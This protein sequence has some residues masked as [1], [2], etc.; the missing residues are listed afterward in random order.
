MSDDERTRLRTEIRRAQ[1]GQPRIGTPH[2]KAKDAKAFDRVQDHL[3]KASIRVNF[4]G[5]P[6]GLSED[7]IEDIVAMIRKRLGGG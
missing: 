6:P 7:E 2:R 3:N 1:F 5:I 4:L